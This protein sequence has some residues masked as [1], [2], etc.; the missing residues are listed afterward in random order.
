MIQVLRKSDS[1]LQ[2]THE[3]DKQKLEDQLREVRTEREEEVRRLTR[4]YE[5]EMESAL[6]KLIFRLSLGELTIAG[7]AG[8]SA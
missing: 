5:Q 6:V 8:R 2:A 3:A 7:E 4:E 1:D